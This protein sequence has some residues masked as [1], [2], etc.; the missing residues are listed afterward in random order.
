MIEW[1]KSV[2]MR[3]VRT[4]TTKHGTRYLCSWSSRLRNATES[5]RPWPGHR[6]HRRHHRHRR[7]R[8]HRRSFPV[9]EISPPTPSFAGTGTGLPSAN[10]IIETDYTHIGVYMCVYRNSE[11]HKYVRTYYVPG[12]ETWLYREY[13]P[14]T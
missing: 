9:R 2:K 13:R 12:A 11:L 6:R 4:A 8:Y 10:G 14:T 5:A 3:R 1:T 7:C